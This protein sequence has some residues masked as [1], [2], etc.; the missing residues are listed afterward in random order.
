M[1]DKQ[2]YEAKQTWLE[3]VMASSLTPAQKVFAFSIFKRCY[4]TKVSSYPATE[5]I[6]E[7]TGLAASKYPAYR[8]EIIDCGA[9]TAVKERRGKYKQENYTYTLNLDWDGTTDARVPTGN[10]PCTQRVV[11]MYPE[12][13]SH[14][15]TGDSNT[16][17]NTINKP[18]SRTTSDGSTAGAVSPCDD[19]LNNEVR[20]VGKSRYSFNYR[21]TY[22]S[23]NHTSRTPFYFITL[24]TATQDTPAAEGVSM[25]DTKS[26]NKAWSEADHIALRNKLLG[27][28][29]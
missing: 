7:D 23:L 17:S 12:G 20:D 15:P 5:H 21:D 13:G 27:R 29:V 22:P 16:T 10:R 28:T 26:H 6:L 3:R 1:N 2:I 14:V 25:R 9:L 4:G 19:S 18:T 11:A 8:R 24:N